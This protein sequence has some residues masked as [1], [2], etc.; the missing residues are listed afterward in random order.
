MASDTARSDDPL[1][2]IDCESM[3][4]APGTKR[5]A[6]VPT[7]VETHSISTRFWWIGGGIVIVALAVGVVIG[8]LL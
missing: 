4:I 6:R 7:D 2:I 1:Q 8:R 3:P 5:G